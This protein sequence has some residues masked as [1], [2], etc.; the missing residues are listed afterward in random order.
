MPSDKNTT[1]P[2]VAIERP[3]S[4][5][6][7]RLTIPESFIGS[8]VRIES[9]EDDT[10]PNRTVC[11]SIPN[12]SRQLSVPSGFLPDSETVLVEDVSE[13]EYIR[14]WPDE[15]SV[16]ETCEYLRIWPDTLD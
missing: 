1:R 4:G 8:Q 15:S 11:R 9:V 5:A 10:A 3:L 16:S 2:N 14:V 6:K 13:E 7:R 12:S